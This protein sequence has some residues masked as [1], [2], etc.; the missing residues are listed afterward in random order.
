[1]KIKSTI[2]MSI[3][4]M[5]SLSSC[6]SQKEVVE[7]T[8]TDKTQVENTAIPNTL[9]IPYF[10][11]IGV[12]PFWNLEISQKQVKFTTLENEKGVVLPIESAK[13]FEEST[14]TTYSTKDFM[15]ILEAIPGGCND[16]MSDLN[17][18]H[19]VTVSLIDEAT[20]EASENYGCGQF[21]ADSKLSNT[22]IL[23]TLRDKNVNSK[24]FG[25]QLPNLQIATETNSFT[26]FAGCNTI[27]GQLVPNSNDRIKFEN[28]ATT[29]M[30]CAPENKEQDFLN[31]LSKVGAYKFDGQTLILLDATYVPVA[32]FRKK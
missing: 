14:K 1:M 18:S 17:Y 6:K 30:M 28:I 7:K 19:K 13:I 12:E 20:G 21:F 22:W 5:A 23:Q 10:K 16:G 27:K 15:L 32:T 29:R 2:V 31:V 3:I 26:G 24:D 11:A 25:D 4:V 9:E 8:A